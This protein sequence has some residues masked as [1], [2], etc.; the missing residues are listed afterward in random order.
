LIGAIISRVSILKRFEW[1]GTARE[2]FSP[3]SLVKDDR[4]ARCRAV[5]HPIGWELRLE[6]DGEVIRA[7]A[8]ADDE[9][10]ILDI[11]AWC[12]DMLGEGWSFS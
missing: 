12:E 3:W 10:M 11:P 2:L 5:T 4:T 7:K 1:D 8:H 9:P 6:I